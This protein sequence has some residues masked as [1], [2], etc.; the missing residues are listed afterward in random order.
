[1]PSPPLATHSCESRVDPAQKT[2]CEWTLLLSAWL[3]E[4]PAAKA[5][6]LNWLAKATKTKPPT[7]AVWRDLN[8]TRNFRSTYTP[9]A[10]T[11]H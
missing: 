5:T 3:A 9:V 10:R 4:G 7:S 1:M 2:C 8:W 11:H 6:T